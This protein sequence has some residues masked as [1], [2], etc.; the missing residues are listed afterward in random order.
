MTKKKDTKTTAAAKKKAAAAKRAAAKKKKDEG[1]KASHSAQV[2]KNNKGTVVNVTQRVTNPS[3]KNQAP[4]AAPAGSVVV[5]GGGPGGYGGGGGGWAPPR[6]PEGYGTGARYHPAL[7]YGNGGYGSAAPLAQ[8]ASAGGYWAGVGPGRVRG[9]GSNRLLEVATGS[10]ENSIGALSPA[11]FPPPPSYIDPEPIG[12]IS[13]LTSAVPSRS[14]SPSR[15]FAA[16]ASGAGAGAGAGAISQD[17]RSQLTNPMIQAPVG[18]GLRTGGDVPM[19]TENIA[20]AHTAPPAMGVGRLRAIQEDI[21]AAARSPATAQPGAMDP[22]GPGDQSPMPRQR[23]PPPPPPPPP[24]STIGSSR[25]PPPPPP[26]RQE[27]SDALETPVQPRQ[28]ALVNQ[29]PPPPPPPPQSSLTQTTRPNPLPPGRTPLSFLDQVRQGAAKLTPIPKDAPKP[30][31]KSAMVEAMEGALG[32][33]R[34][35][36]SADDDKSDASSL[37]SISFGG[38][39]SKV[40]KKDLSTGAGSGGGSEREAQDDTRSQKSGGS[41]AKDDTRSQK[42][43]GSGAKDDTRSQKSGGSGAKDDTRSQKSGGS[44]AKDDTKDDTK[45]QVS[46]ETEYSNRDQKPV[47]LSLPRLS[48]AVECPFCTYMVE[49]TGGSYTPN[50]GGQYKNPASFMKHLAIEH[51]VKGHKLPASETRG[52]DTPREFVNNQVTRMAP[53]GK[54]SAKQFEAWVENIQENPKA[55][56][57][58]YVG[59]PS[60]KEKRPPTQT[61]QPVAKTA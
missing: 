14:V 30:S 36:I 38:G 44:G 5:S 43:G 12:S 45:T 8:A 16:A 40:T 50:N 28:A 54:M 24:Q 35:K 23:P 4:V 20:A 21:M 57:Q 3:S 2:G 55:P 33:L 9:E 1:K 22:E 53:V 46:S 48:K 47:T 6:G 10:Y 58:W 27:V 31:K 17:P 37:S 59:R 25:P 56:L 29:V 13:G 15:S 51:H 7:W 52:Y 39:T 32:K 60:G 42:S 26:P 61:A 41:G 34:L 11:V 18:G 49:T 19:A